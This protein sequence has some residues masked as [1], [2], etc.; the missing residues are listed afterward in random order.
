MS[1]KKGISDGLM[2]KKDFDK[3][4]PN[5]HELSYKKGIDFGTKLKKDISLKEQL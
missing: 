1:F 2:E 3:S 4:I 5:G